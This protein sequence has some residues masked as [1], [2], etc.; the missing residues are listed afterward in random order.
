MLDAISIGWPVLDAML[1]CGTLPGQLDALHEVGPRRSKGK[2]K[3][4][5]RARKLREACR[6]SHRSRESAAWNLHT[7]REH[8][9]TAP[10][11][12]LSF[13]NRNINPTSVDMAMMSGPVNNVRNSR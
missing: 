6:L 5:S 8:Q 10:A 11:P 3:T 9:G 2:K 12:S 7:N 4:L 1:F 13:P